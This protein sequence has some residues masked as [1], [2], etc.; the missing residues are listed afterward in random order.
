M[1]NI[2]EMEKQLSLAEQE[3]T[4]VYR[5]AVQVFLTFGYTCQQHCHMPT[6]QKL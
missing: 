5:T 3:A 1:K 6:K 4:F 2:R